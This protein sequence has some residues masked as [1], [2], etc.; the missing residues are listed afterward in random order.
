[1]SILEKYKIPHCFDKEYFN[2]VINRAK[3]K[4]TIN[5]FVEDIVI[6]GLDNNLNLEKIT[7]KGGRILYASNHKSHLDYIILGYVIAMNNLPIPRFAAGENLLCWPLNKIID[8]RKM[9]AFSIDRK[10]N[11]NIEYLRELYK[12]IGNLIENKENILFF[13]E[14]G[15]NYNEGY[16]K[17]Q[18]GL[19]RAVMNA[20]DKNNIKVYVEP[21]HIKYD[22]VAEDEIFSSLKK[23]KFK[24]IFY[25]LLDSYA[26]TKRYFGKEKGKI[27]IK[28]GSPA[29]IKELGK[30]KKEV[31]DKIID[32]IIKIG[33]ENVR[34]I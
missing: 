30:N 20:V 25:Y 34:K 2:N 19:I 33:E 9:G 5:K 23:V 1:M 13:P 15:R 8:F 21:I 27:Y 24:S 32:M 31:A 6:G 11:G 29:E 18:T 17:P 7:N 26:L 4:K 16:R 22:I 28:F 10:K 14:G 12:Y 3:R